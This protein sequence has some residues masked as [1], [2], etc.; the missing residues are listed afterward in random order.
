[1]MSPVGRTQPSW[2]RSEFGL[3]GEY[4]Q[5]TEKYKEGRNREKQEKVESEN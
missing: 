3:K 4:N 2:L 1:M 5:D